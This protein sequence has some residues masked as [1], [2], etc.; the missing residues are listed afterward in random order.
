MPL[1]SPAQIPEILQEA[2]KTTKS[3]NPETMKE[4]LNRS[5]LTLED[6][7]DNVA[8]IMRGADSSSARLQAAKLAAEMQ[9]ILQKDEIKNPPSVTIVIQDS[10]VDINPILVP[11]EVSF[12]S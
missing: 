6:I 8:C 11:R 1:L 5:G 10:A 9:G 12:G 3:E 7:A 4:I 2:R